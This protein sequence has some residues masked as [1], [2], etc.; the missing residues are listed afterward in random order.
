MASRVVNGIDR[1]DRQMFSDEPPPDLDA[2]TARQM[3]AQLFELQETGSPLPVGLRA[4]AES[5]ATRR[6]AREF[7]ALAE[8]LEQGSSPDEIL[9]TWSSRVPSHVLGL[10]AAASRAGKEPDAMLQLLEQEQRQR[11]V[12]RRVWRALAYPSIMLLF[13]MVLFIAAQLFIIQPMNQVF[14]EFQLAL[15][16]P[17]VMMLWW[18]DLGISMVPALL[19]VLIASAVVCRATLPA[20]W[21]HL[22]LSSA[23]FVGEVHWWSGTARFL[24]LLAMLLRHDVPIPE[25]LR[26]VQAALPDASLQQVCQAVQHKVAAGIPFSRAL[27]DTPGFP[28]LVCAYVE[29][30]ELQNSLFEACDAAAELFEDRVSIRLEVL[31]LIVPAVVFLFTL[32]LVAFTAALIMLPMISLISGLT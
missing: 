4:A 8:R 21:W 31:R 5:A 11:D 1:G 3:L 22:F 30:G 25:A 7:R 26:L 6:L 19:L 18:G 10:L 13:A 27:A 9:D 24:R 28:R 15:P 29:Q 23:P 16:Q 12:Q 20:A 17:L 32:C 2:S 14:E